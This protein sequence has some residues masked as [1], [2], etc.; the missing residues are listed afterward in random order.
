MRVLFH[1]VAVRQVGGATRLITALAQGLRSVAPDCEATFLL[2][3]ELDVELPPDT[4][5][6][7]VGIR[8]ALGRA[9]FDTLRWKSYV[10][11]QRPDVLVLLFGFGPRSPSVPTLVFL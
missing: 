5:V 4:G 3:K 1:A 9:F 7:R 8:G 10:Y 11:P 6:L 2:H